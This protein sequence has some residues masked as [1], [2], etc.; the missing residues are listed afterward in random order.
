MRA[1]RVTYRTR[2]KEL[3]KLSMSEKWGGSRLGEV[4][5]KLAI[6]QFGKATLGSRERS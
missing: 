5:Q 3:Q 6:A 1:W 4:L 2:E